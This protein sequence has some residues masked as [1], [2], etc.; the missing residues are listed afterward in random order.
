MK[1]RSLCLA[2]EAAR[3]E[4]T[5]SKGVGRHKL[6]TGIPLQSCVKWPDHCTMILLQELTWELS[7]YIPCAPTFCN[8]RFIFGRHYVR[9][10]TKAVWPRLSSVPLRFGC[11]T[12]W[13]V[14]VFGSDGL[15]G[16]RV[17]FVFLHLKRERSSSGSGCGS[18]KTV[19]A[20]LV[21]V[22]VSV[23]GK[24]ALVVPVRFLGLPAKMGLKILYMLGLMRKNE[25]VIPMRKNQKLIPET[26]K[27]A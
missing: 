13:A 6:H 17:S 21:E 16:E 19:P 8:I 11:G 20:V 5:Q 23:P 22:P 26:L 18:W 27:S 4:G 24:T 1:S 9:K 2:L 12:V 15:S 14:P 7:F 25:K 3:E 10:V